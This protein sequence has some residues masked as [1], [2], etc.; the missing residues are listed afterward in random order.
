MMRR[1]LYLCLF[2][3][4]LFTKVQAGHIIGGEI[5]Y[6]CLGA[7]GTDSTQYEITIKVY[8]DCENPVGQN[9]A[10]FDN[11]LALAIY[12]NN[13]FVLRQEPVFLDSRD[14]IPITITDP[15]LVSIPDVCVEEGIYID[16]LILRNSNV[17]YTISYARCCRSPI[18]DNLFLP[19]D[20]GI[21]ITTAIPPNS[22]SCNSSPVITDFPPVGICANRD[23]IFDHSAVDPDGD[24]LSY[25]FCAPFQVPSNGNPGA[26]ALPPPY[27]TVNYAQGFS[28]A[29]PIQANPGLAIDPVTGIITGT[30]TQVGTFVV[31]V[32][33]TEYRNGI[34]ISTVKRDFTINTASCD[35]LIIS[36]AQDQISSCDGLSV[37]FIN[38]SSG[39]NQFFW[40]FGVVGSLADT[41]NQTSPTFIFPDTGVYDIT[42]IAGPGGPCDDTSVVTFKVFGELDADFSIPALQCLD[43]NQLNVEVAGLFEP[44]ATFSWDFGSSASVQTATTRTVNNVS[45]LNAGVY[46][47]QLVVRQGQCTDTVAKTVEIGGNPIANFGFQTIDNCIPVEVQF[48]DSSITDANS[49]GYFWEFGDG[50]TSTLQNP[51]KIYN[52]AG[53]YAVS[54]QVDQKDRCIDTSLKISLDSI[55]VAQKTEAFF[56]AGDPQCFNGNEFNYVAT[57]NISSTNTFEWFFGNRASIS[58]SNSQSAIVSYDTTGRFPVQ[59]IVTQD[60]CADTLLQFAEVFEN[61][62]IDFAISDDTICFPEQVQFTDLSTAASPLS[63]LWF[64]GNGDSSTTQNP[65]VRYDTAGLYNVFLQ[66]RTEEKC[67]DTLFK[68]V[69][70]AVLVYPRPNGGFY[71][72]DSSASIKTP[73]ITFTDTSSSWTNRSLFLGDGRV[74]TD[75]LVYH[76]YREVGKFE[77]VQIVENQFFCSDTTTKTIEITDVFEFI[78]PNVFTPNGDGINDLLRPTLCGVIDYKITIVDRWGITKFTSITPAIGW[79]GRV[80]GYKSNTGTYFYIAEITDFTGK[81][82][83]F[84]GTVNLFR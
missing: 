11:P 13:S 44:F 68:T 79:D 67:V 49:I 2:S 1:I 30:P 75:S 55:I 72:S 14:T 48:T 50:T 59:L 12:E 58:Q 37:T 5:Y 64:F 8:R 77:V 74:S 78:M 42:L 40:D 80:D 7:V 45:F 34:P 54:L 71:F 21:I 69:D 53:K 61:P 62:T 4:T 65:I 36:S 33:V 66:V 17:G 56:I 70:S 24:S 38:Q 16:T 73:F 82:H 57:G 6:S 19:A 15:C 29:N 23:F 51:T 3:F 52:Q 26:V 39:T 22:I 43:T 81:D 47:I 60:G 41:S 28:D 20:Q 9:R 84:K 35:P 46:P 25:A 18:I 27:N 31:G 83:V 63:Y 10:D 76:E 32:C